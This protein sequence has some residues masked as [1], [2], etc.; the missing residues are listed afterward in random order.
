MVSSRNACVC[1]V[2]LILPCRSH[3]PG[4]PCLSSCSVQH[5]GKC[6]YSH[7]RLIPC[8]S[9]L[10]GISGP[11]PPYHLL[12]SPFIPLPLCIPISEL[13][14][15]PSP[16][17]FQ[18]TSHRM[19]QGRGIVYGETAPCQPDLFSMQPKTALAEAVT[20]CMQPSLQCWHGQRGDT[21]T[22][23]AHPGVWMKG[24]QASSNVAQQQTLLWDQPCHL[25]DESWC[26]SPHGRS[27]G[28]V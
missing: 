15:F 11:S 8:S 22:K 13:L 23:V 4:S 6:I 25:W 5:C 12:S 9:S 1:W 18:E 14:S 16:S 19:A 7:I 21:A 28:S 26:C 10:P 20:R 27:G 2:G 24:Q 17:V 3:P